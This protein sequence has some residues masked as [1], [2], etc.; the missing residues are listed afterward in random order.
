MA[1]KALYGPPADDTTRILPKTQ[2]YPGLWLPDSAPPRRIDSFWHRP[3]AVSMTWQAVHDYPEDKETMA[4]EVVCPP[5]P[6]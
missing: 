5:R 4:A 3:M 6:V 1:A 2:V